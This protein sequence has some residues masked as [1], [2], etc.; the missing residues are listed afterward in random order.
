MIKIYDNFFDEVTHIKIWD[1]CNKVSYKIG[2][3]DHKKSLPTGGIFSISNKSKLFSLLDKNLVDKFE[4]L[5]NLKCYRAY[6]NFF[7][8]NE[9]PYFH[10]DN[11]IG[12]TCLFYPNIDFELNEGGE[13]QFLINNEIRGILPIP[14]RMILFDAKIDHKATSF[15]SRHRFTLAIK[16]Q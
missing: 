10:Q 2:E 16:Y 4:Q 3:K 1:Y 7:S 12:Y 5:K 9:N 8:F 15:R 6:I 11:N 13:T 14:N